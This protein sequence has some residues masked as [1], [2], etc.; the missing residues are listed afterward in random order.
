MTS[1]SN[2]SARLTYI[3]APWVRVVRVTW[4]V[5]AVLAVGVFAASLP[6]YLVRL[7][8]GAHG[9][10]L[11][12]TPSILQIALNLVNI[13]V[14]ISAVLL[15][16]GLAWLL[17]RQKSNERMVMFLSFYLLVYAV[18]FA[19]PL[20]ALIAISPGFTESFYYM[21]AGVFIGPMTVALFALLPDGRFVP[22]WTRWLI[23][24]SLLLIPVSIFFEDVSTKSLTSALLW[25][26]TALAL[27]ILLAS[28]YAQIYRYRKV[29]TQLEKLQTKWVI[30]GLSMWFLFMLIS[31]YPYL[32]IESLP[33][34]SQLPW[35][36][37]IMELVWFTSLM[38]LPLSL[39]IAVMRYRLY[40]IDILINRTIVYG[41]L[42][43]IVVGLYVLVVGGLGV[44]LQASGNLLIALIATGIVAVL[45]QPL[46]ERLQQAVNRM[47][48]GERDDPV[49]VFTRLGE[50]MEANS[51]PKAMLSGLVET[52]A[53]TLKLPYTAIELEADS[54]IEVLAVYGSPAREEI[55]FPLVYQTEQIGSLVVSPRTAGG[56]FSQKD[57]RLLENIT[58]Q[59]GAAAY[60]VRLNLKLQQ[61]RARL[62]T[63]REEERRRI[64]RDLHDELGPQLASQTLIV[65]ALE[66][67]MQ[68]DPDSA[69][70]LLRELKKH[71][72][73][74]IQ[75]I[76]RLVYDLRPPVLDD[77]GL[78]NAIREVLATYHQS[79]I[80]CT[81]EA[82]PDPLPPLAAAVEV[83]TFRIVQEAVTNVM[84]HAQ[85]EHCAVR[86]EYSD[87]AGDAQLIVTV[88][89]DGVGIPSRKRAGVGMQSMR[90]RA[91]ELGGKCV[92]ESRAEGGTR[93]FAQL[94]MPGEIS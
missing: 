3:Q 91:A 42:T 31:S 58:G 57:R 8:A 33:P 69:I 18:G 89:D 59:T 5:I 14:S 81:V 1:T 28:L 75:D 39:T 24:A 67:R 40:D 54:D 84:R 88:D 94:P 80:A 13:L 76:R 43:A 10:A 22:D 17:F 66:K 16:F 4:W 77:L 9:I 36:T 83:A 70:H 27:L 23:L 44:L 86:I 38:F 61:S 50:M 7:S 90:E 25:I 26:G 49:T 73:F 12:S 62:V 68:N 29:S 60:A 85:A 45:F 64:R 37:P 30:F 19:G 87:F 2:Q 74:A 21:I 82:T 51:N 6:G 48:Y 78:V 41:A 71:T 55:R 79:R 15:S 47:M 72:Q 46:R 63:A 56:G 53:Q 65:E 52:I 34:G 35:W 32:I 20:E 93:V 11:A 92:I